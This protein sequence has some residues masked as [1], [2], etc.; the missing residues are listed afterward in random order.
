MSKRQVAVVVLTA[1]IVSSS[2]CSAVLGSDQL[3]WN[4]ER[5]RAYC[6]WDNDN[7]KARN[8]TAWDI[9]QTPTNYTGQNIRI[10][11]LDTGMDYSVQNGTAYP[12]PDLAQ[13]V[14]GFWG[15]TGFYYDPSGGQVIFFHD[16][17]NDPTFIQDTDGHGTEVA[18]V[19]AAAI[20]GIGVIGVAPNVTIY[21]LKINPK[22]RSDPYWEWEEEEEVAAAIHCA[23]YSL[24]VNI[25][26]ISMDWTPSNSDLQSNCT[27]AANMGVLIFVAAGNDNQAIWQYPALYSNGTSTYTVSA[28][29]AIDQNDTRSS[30]SNYGP[31]LIF[32]APGDNVTTTGLAGTYTNVSG[33]SFSAPAAAAVAALICSSKVQPDYSNHWDWLSVWHKMKDTV[34]N[35]GTSGWNN[36]TGWG[37]VNAWMSNQRPLGDV[38][39][40]HKVDGKDITILTLAWA[41]YPGSSNWDP[42]AD[43]NI[44]KKVDGKDLTIVVL[45]Y[46]DHTDP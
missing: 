44:D 6:V 10:A 38:N 39:N 17:V 23:V 42:R 16:P 13:N 4:V 19:I 33:T 8:T 36:Y 26:S 41:S 35:L 3:P 40:D 45:H 30:Y 28:V 34:Y 21:S 22:P 24:E 7:A 14:A 43:I 32:V 18:G 37:L 11:I 46:G 25:I 15:M 31:K 20:N 12:H 1:V 5:I 27:D 9:D 29:G 2:M